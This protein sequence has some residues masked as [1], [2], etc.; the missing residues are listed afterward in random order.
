MACID[1]HT[2]YYHRHC[3]R[4][5]QVLMAVANKERMCASAINRHTAQTV[6]MGSPRMRS[7]SYPPN[8]EDKST[9]SSSIDDRLVADELRE[10]FDQRYSLMCEHICDG[11]S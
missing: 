5:L 11:A 7:S 4:V 6:A 9:Q 1:S 3:A 8:T 10:V 2:D